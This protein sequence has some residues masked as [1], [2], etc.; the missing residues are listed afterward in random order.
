MHFEDMKLFLN[1]VAICDSAPILCLK[2]AATSLTLILPRLL[3]DPLHR[4]QAVS[5]SV[6]GGWNHSFG[7]PAGNGR[8]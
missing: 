2:V 8:L 3:K 4:V 7:G 1:T 5:P 6:G